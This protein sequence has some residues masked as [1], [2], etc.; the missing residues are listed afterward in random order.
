MHT[1]LLVQWLAYSK[2][3]IDEE[4]EED[5]IYIVPLVGTNE[6]MSKFPNYLMFRDKNIISNTFSRF[7]KI[8]IICSWGILRCG[9]ETG[10]SD[11]KHY[12][13]LSPL[14]VF[15]NFKKEA[16]NF[17]L[18]PC[19]RHGRACR[20]GICTRTPLWL[21]ENP[22]QKKRNRRHRG[23]SGV[24]LERFLSILINELK[25]DILHSMWARI[26]E[27]KTFLLKIQMGPEI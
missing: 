20:T 5:G 18:F 25:L 24:L 2:Y 14:R 15:L 4:K 23:T 13:S 8:H 26:R 17:A 7:L 22:Y 3:Q 12:E 6:L 21:P 9:L 1:R 11:K 27:L 10:I 19:S 16:S